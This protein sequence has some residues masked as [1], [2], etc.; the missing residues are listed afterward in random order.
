MRSQAYLKECVREL[1]RE[2]QAAKKEFKKKYGRPFCMEKE[3]ILDAYKYGFELSLHEGFP[4]KF[5]S[6]KSTH[7]LPTEVSLFEKGRY[8]G[9]QFGKLEVEA[10]RERILDEVE[11]LRRRIYESFWDRLR[12]WR[13]R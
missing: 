9:Q 10:A 13:R 4:D 5:P 3:W 12:F 2:F 11:T 6:P 8:V 7:L 1:R